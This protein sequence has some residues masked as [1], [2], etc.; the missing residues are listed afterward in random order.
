MAD[1]F[2]ALG[3]NLGDR[4]NNL[5]RALAALSRMGIVLTAAS[6]VYETEPWGPVKQSPYLNQVVRARTKLPPHALLRA[7]RWVERSL[8]RDRSREQRFG[9]RTMDLDLLVYE[10]ARRNTK[11]LQLPHPRMLQRPFVLVPLAEIA[12]ALSVNGITVRAALARAGH[13]GV[14]RLPNVN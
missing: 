6:S 8:G 7:L 9:P 1:V 5:A 10:G 13:S 14:V 12:P 3:G 2:I 4:K 11:V